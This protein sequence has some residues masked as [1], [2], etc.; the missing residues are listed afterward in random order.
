M[1]CTPG[2]TCKDDACVAG[3][4]C[5]DPGDVCFSSQ[6]CCS[7]QCS[8]GECLANLP[9]TA[10]AGADRSAPYHA[11]VILDGSAST[12]PNGDS[13]SFDWTLSPPA[14][15]AAALSSSTSPRP[16][17]YADVA[18]VYTAVLT[19]SDGTSASSATVRIDA[20]NFPPDANAGL[21]RTV[22]KNN[23]QTLDASASTDANGDAMSFAWALTSLPPG[24]GAAFADATLAKPTFTPDLAGTYVATVTVS[25]GALSGSAFVEIVALDTVPVADAGAAQAANAGTPVTLDGTASSDADHDALAYSWAMTS[26]PDASGASLSGASSAHPSFTPDVE[27]VYSFSLTVSDGRNASA[28][29]TATVTAHHAIA[30]LAHDVVDAEYSPALDRIVMVSGAPS[31]ALYEY[32]PEAGT[33]VMVALN[34]VPLS[35]SVSPDGTF[36]AVGHD[37]MVSL[38]DLVAGTRLAEFGTTTKVGD[39][40]LGAVSATTSVTGFAYAFPDQ[41]AGWTHIV[42][43]DLSSGEQTLSTPAY[44]YIHGGT[45]AKLHPS[46]S[47]IYGADNGISPSD[48]EDYPIDAKG[49]ANYGWDSPYHGD[50]PVCGDLWF[51]QDGAHIFTAC[52]NVFVATPA[53][54]NVPSSEPPVPSDMVYAGSLQEIVA[55]QHASHSALAQ[56][57]LVIPAAGWSTSSTADTVF[58]SFDDVYFTRLTG[59]T[60]AL[61]PWAGPGPGYVAHGRFVFWRSD[62]TRRYA[63]LQGDAA[64]PAA[65]RWGVVA[66]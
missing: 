43:V 16:T 34:K 22:P 65:P 37:A 10:S 18:G 32:D 46:G 63:I 54:R 44:S 20:R 8:S 1:D 17:F 26:R 50:H 39:V 49:V 58:E 42:T 60:V 61:P 15:S 21:R 48:L 35:V 64:T 29:S 27:G 14:G 4:V 47:A 2:L 56:A 5:R 30:A 11:T 25:D 12:D 51:S 52:G 66:Y 23:P 9:P 36:A 41:T 53:S 59:S 45:L 57:L 24:S 7:G 3:A 13:L 6:Q 55:V 31:N 38:V 19:V 28:A 62:A 33:E 40:V